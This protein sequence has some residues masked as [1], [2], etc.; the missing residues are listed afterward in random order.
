MAL[1]IV[2][3]FDYPR[4]MVDKKPQIIKKRKWIF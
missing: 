4:L 1:P 2:V 3:Q